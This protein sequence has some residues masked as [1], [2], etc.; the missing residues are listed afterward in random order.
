MVVENSLLYYFVRDNAAAYSENFRFLDRSTPFT[1]ALNGSRYAL[2][3]SS[4]HFAKRNNPDEY[5]IQVDRT[6]FDELRRH[7]D[8]GARVRFIGVFDSGEAFV[9]WDPRYGFSLTAQQRVSLYCRHSQL[10]AVT[11][12]LSAVYRFRSQNLGGQTSAIALSAEAL[13][14]YLENAEHFHALHDDEVISKLMA[15]HGN[16]MIAD[17]GIGQSGDIDVED[18]KTRETFTY[19]RASYRRDPKFR[20]NVLEAYGRTCCICDR[21]LGLVEAAH[22]IPHAEDDSSDHISNGLAMCIEHHRLY[23]RALLLPGPGR[24]LIFNEERA[25]YLKAMSQQKGLKEIEKRNRTTYNIP[26]NP[27]QQPRDEYLERGLVVR[28]GR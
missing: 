10:S 3:V 25:E 15:T 5:R 2:H 1:I 18:S 26:E 14:F 20:E 6:E 21:Q 22:I 16:T 27:D 13:G 19:T 4:I 7:Q 8:A 9:G 23:D 11:R 24:Q 28:M 17:E 12:E